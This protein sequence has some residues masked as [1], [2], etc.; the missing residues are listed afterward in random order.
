MCHLGPSIFFLI[1]LIT[2][3]VILKLFDGISFLNSQ[4]LE[5]RIVPKMPDLIPRTQKVLNKSLSKKN[6]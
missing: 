2:F 4:L 3:H 6:D 1:L 5:S